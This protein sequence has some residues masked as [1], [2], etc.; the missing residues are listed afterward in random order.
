[1][2]KNRKSSKYIQMFCA[3]SLFLLFVLCSLLIISI[4]ASNYKGIRGDADKNFSANSSI[5]YVSNKLHAYDIKGGIATS[6]MNGIDVILL[7]DTTTEGYNTI[8][9]SYKNAI[10]E[11]LIQKGNSFNP[12]DGEKIINV[13]NFSFEAIGENAIMLKA[14]NAKGK[15]ISSVIL[16]RCAEIDTEV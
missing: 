13:K 11:L 12:G 9:Y 4:A 2:N 8:I 14:E 6:K 15:T 10:Y 1:M 3:L 7:T 16:L 5:R